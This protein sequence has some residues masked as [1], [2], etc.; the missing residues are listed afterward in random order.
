MEQY[1]RLQG[2]VIC[3]QTAED[4]FIFEHTPDVRKELD[5]VVVCSYAEIK[6]NEDQIVGGVSDNKLAVR[7]KVYIYNE[8]IDKFILNDNSVDINFYTEQLTRFVDFVRRLGAESCEYEISIDDEDVRSLEN[9]TKATVKTVR[10]DV[11]VNVRSKKTLEE[12]IR[13]ILNMKG[14]ALT[15]DDYKKAVELFN[16]TPMLRNCSKC[17]MLLLGRNPE[18]NEIND[19]EFVYLLHTG[20]QSSIDVAAKISAFKILKV[21]NDFKK[22]KEVNKLVCVK[23]KVKFKK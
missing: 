11:E 1:E 6:A 10:A 22:K 3:V 7:G 19:L 9:K 13:V 5:G 17:K 15:D 14:K 20:L 18:E 4:K 2:K 16:T 8:A 23:F 12:M 21:E